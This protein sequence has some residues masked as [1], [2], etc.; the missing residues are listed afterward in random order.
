MSVALEDCRGFRAGVPGASPARQRAR[1]SGV[2]R[3]SGHLLESVSSVGCGR[4]RG[5]AMMPRGTKYTAEQITGK[6]REA[7]AGLARRKTAAEV[8]RKR[9]VTEQTCCRLTRECDGL[10]TD[11]ARRLGDR[12]AG[13]VRG[14]NR[15]GRHRRVFAPAASGTA[16]PRPR[17][18]PA[19][20][21]R[22]PRRGPDSTSRLKGRTAE[23]TV[24]RPHRGPRGRLIGSPPGSTEAAP[25][26][27]PP[28]TA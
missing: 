3:I 1:R 18:A 23:V 25:G 7:E 15:R 21:P 4:S 28:A 26:E 19:F 10:R 6:L 9:G 20:T 27:R 8:V 24:G 12:A 16:L 22:H 2:C 13:S 5:R 14:R 17:P 11:Q